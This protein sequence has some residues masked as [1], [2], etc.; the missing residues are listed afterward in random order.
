MGLKTALMAVV[1]AF[2]PAAGFTPSN[3]KVRTAPSHLAAKKPQGFAAPRKVRE[4]SQ[5]RVEK[6]RAAAA[7]DAAKAAGTPEYRVYVKA[8]GTESWLPVGCITVPRSEPVEQAIFGNVEALKK[9]ALATYPQLRSLVDK[10][11]DLEYGYNLAV[12]P[13]DPVRLAQ[14]QAVAQTGNPFTKWIKDLTS[15]VNAAS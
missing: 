14:P 9:S 5:S 1:I 10:D 13:D 4:K 15:P 11:G 2:Y 6:E 12:F 3:V 8:E 7:Y